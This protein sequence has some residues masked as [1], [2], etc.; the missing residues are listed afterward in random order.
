VR[1][2]RE[3]RPTVVAVDWSGA[4]SVAAQRAGI[5]VAISCGDAIET[6]V[7]V[8]R[9]QTIDLVARLRPPVVVGFDFSFGFPQWFAAEYGCTTIAEV[10]ALAGREG[11]TW[12]RPVPPFWRDRCEIPTERRFRACERKLPPA[13]S[14]FQLVGN[15]QV[16]AG[17]VRGMPLIAQLR[18]EGFAIWPFDTPD[19]RTALEIYPSRLRR[20]MRHDQDRRYG[21]AHERD[22]VESV[23][24]M[25]DR[26]DLFATLTATTD[27]T[28]RIE[29]DIW[30]PT[31]RGTDR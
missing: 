26:R 13:K 6:T 2:L 24:V 18:A 5:C 30:M 23:R 17:S 16:G 14:I 10:W 19:E 21:S 12:L 31:A 22:A 15:G 9:N 27:P 29:G 1:D 8:T 7:G 25:W 3:F 4:R 28:T 20:L 11:E